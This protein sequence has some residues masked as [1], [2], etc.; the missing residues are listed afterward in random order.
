M[1]TDRGI[2]FGKKAKYTYWGCMGCSRGM[3]SAGGYDFFVYG[4]K[5]IFNIIINKRWGDMAIGPR[6]F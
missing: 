3:Y 2:L 1:R 6:R 4:I 5:G